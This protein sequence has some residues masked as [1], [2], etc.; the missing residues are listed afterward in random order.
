MTS[1]MACG[2]VDV[3]A[4]ADPSAATEATLLNGA[5]DPGHRFDVG[6]CSGGIGAAGDANEGL[7]KKAKC[8]GTLIAPNLVLTARHCI[9]KIDYA[10]AFCDSTFNDKPITDQ[11]V[12]VTTSPSTV[13]GTPKWYSVKAELLPE[14]RSLCADDVA[15]L[16]L[17]TPVPLREAL[18]TLVN[19]YRDLA[20]RPAAEVAIVGRGV[21]SE[22][23]NL[24]TGQTTTVSGDLKRRVL[25]HVSFDC[26]TN[27]ASVPCDT[28]DYSSPPSNAFASPPSYFIIGQSITSGDS[29]SA[30]L[31]QA[32]FGFLPIVIGVTSAATFGPDGVPNHGLVTRL[33]IHR[34]FIFSGFWAAAS[35]LGLRAHSFDSQA[36]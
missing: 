31:D 10:D 18:P 9:R 32:T 24:E 26:A 25:Q 4:E 6:I 19:V 27:E 22:V 23:L 34:N 15:M 29:G 8:S 14:N 16:L 13:V 35:S 17:D 5:E 36:R 12:L 33:D 2:P 28:V 21:I 3:V 11:K 7:C 1:A 30:V 20:S